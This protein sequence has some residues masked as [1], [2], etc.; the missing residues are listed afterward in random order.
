M[1]GTEEE[2]ARRCPYPARP[3]LPATATEVTLSAPACRWGGLGESPRAPVLG[4]T[5]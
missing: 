1:E 2:A 5:S 3:S 4:P